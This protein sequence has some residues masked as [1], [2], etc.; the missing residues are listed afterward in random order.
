MFFNN[1]PPIIALHYVSN[2]PSL[3]DLRPW[4][5]S[6]ESFIR[7]LDYLEQ[8]GYS[9]VTFEDF[10]YRKPSQGKSVII[11]FDDCPRHLWDFAIPELMKRNMRA[12]FYMPTAYIGGYSEWNVAAGL[13]GIDLMNEKEIKQLVEVGMEV[14]AHSHHHVMLSQQTASYVIEELTKSKIILEAIIEKEVIS[15]AYPYG[16][17]PHNF[18][19]IARQLNIDAAL[20][21]YTTDDSKYALRRF[22][23]DDT[24]T[25]E[26]LRW[27]LSTYYKVYRFFN[28]KFTIL[29]KKYAQ[30]LYR[31]YAS[32]KHRFVV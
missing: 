20:S 1:Y 22:I 5:I 26:T 24:D 25:L 32:V 13:S 12:V 15:V 16:D 17:V 10:K 2:D 11:T 7:L 4:V 31:V 30:R 18:K 14:G 29:G 23:Y 9:T 28:D 27:K 8:E 19:T 21:V 3:D 6:H